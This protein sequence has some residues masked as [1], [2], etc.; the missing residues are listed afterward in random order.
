M[1][2]VPDIV[3]KVARLGQPGLAITDH[4]T[5]GGVFQLYKRCKAVGILPFPGIELY[6]VDNA[7][8]VRAAKS[9][10]RYHLGLVAVDL[11]GYQALVR[12]TTHSHTEERFYRKPLVDFDDLSRLAASGAT[13][14]IVCTTGCYFSMLCQTLVTKGPAAAKQVLRMLAAWFPHLYVE[15]QNHW[16]EDDHSTPPHSDYELAL[17]LYGMANELGLPVVAT[18]D[19]HYLEKAHQEP[20]N[21]MK[22]LAYGSQL[23]DDEFPGG[24]YHVASAKYMSGLFTGELAPIWADAEASYQ[25]ILDLNTLA[26]PPLDTYRFL[27][28]HVTNT[29]K[30]DLRAMVAQK[31]VARGVD[32]SWDETYGKKGRYAVRAKEEL[33]VICSTGF[34]SYFLMV[35]DIARWARGQGIRAQ[36]RGSANG[37]LVCFLLGIS[38]IDPLKWGLSMGAFLTRDRSKPPD[39]DLDV[40]QLRRHELVAYV[41]RRYPCEQQGTVGRWGYDEETGKG[42]LYLQHINAEL[43]RMG[44]VAFDA[45]YP[46][47]AHPAQAIRRADPEMAEQLAALNRLRPYKSAGA[48]AAGW[49]LD[50]KQHPLAD[51]VP[52]MRIASSGKTV[53]QMTMDDLEKGGWNKLDMLGSGTLEVIDRCR[54]LLGMSWHDIESTPLDDKEVWR[55]IAK[56]QP[57]NGTFQ[58]DGYSTSKGARTLVPNNIGELIDVVSLFRPGVSP[59]AVASYLRNRRR[60]SIPSFHPLVDPILASTWGE[61]VYTEQVLDIAR[62][63][64]MSPEDVQSILQAMKVKHGKAGF[65]AQSK[66]AFD[67]AQHKF[68]EACEDAGMGGSTAINLWERIEGFNRY[69]FKKA[70][71]TAYGLQAY[72]TCWLRWH[73]PAQFYVSLLTTINETKPEDMPRYER[74]A[75][76]R[77]VKLLPPMLNLSEAG[78]TLEGQAVRRGLASIKGVGLAAAEELAANGPYANVEEIRDRCSAKL[79]SGTKNWFGKEAKFNGVMLLLQEA[80]ALES[81]DIPEGEGRQMSL[82][83]VRV[84]P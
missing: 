7:D 40:Q 37:S 81:I 46:D 3:D 39:I 65:N 33:D 41:K 10:E 44:R 14:H 23:G 35:E 48:H 62:A 32:P 36:T 80:G 50:S 60:K 56:S 42:S 49:V 67:A 84:S 34:A 11:E 54:A 68:I 58:L 15:I 55:Q 79:V 1:A 43:R 25:S 57:D 29:P 70:H 4:G 24:P 76:Q 71:A 74:A 45:K 22:S 78:W 27:M 53:T 59:E 8:R 38:H 30:K 61:F 26:I 63:V 77:G 51:Y 2:G 12:L 17:A 47:A 52:M 64:G 82:L 69:A 83:K 6:M 72:W 20:H 75:R 21:V 16:I 13:E 9:T 18:Q 19:S 28:P 31:L 66:D 5:M 73:Y